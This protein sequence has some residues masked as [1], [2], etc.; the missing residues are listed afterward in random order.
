MPNFLNHNNL[1]E[2]DCRLKLVKKQIAFTQLKYEMAVINNKPI[3]I[4]EDL[5]YELENLHRKHN[6]FC[7]ATSKYPTKQ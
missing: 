5:N 2:L 1:H 6:W 4:L 7:G 3:D